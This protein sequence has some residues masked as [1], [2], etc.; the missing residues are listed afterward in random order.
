M[1][2]HVPMFNIYKEKREMEQIG[3]TGY[4]GYCSGNVVTVPVQLC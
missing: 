4:T 1:Q 2:V 3:L